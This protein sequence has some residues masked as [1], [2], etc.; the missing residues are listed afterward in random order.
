MPIARQVKVGAF[1][2]A[3][4]VVAGLVVF[5]IGDERRL[6]ESKVFYHAYFRDVQGLNRGSPVRMGGIDIGRVEEVSYMEDAKDA[7]LRVTMEIVDEEA[8][9]IRKD[10][11]ATVASKG[12]LGDKM[13]VITVGTPKEPQIPHGGIIP[14]EEAQDI[15]AMLDR[16]NTIGEKAENIAKNLEKTT[17]TFAEDQFREDV[18]ST[19]SSLNSILKSIDKGDGAASRFLHDPAEGER[20]S[21]TLANLERSTAQL[22]KTLTG[23]NA[24]INRVNTGPGFAH[25]VIYGEGPTETVK[26]FGRAAGELATT[27]EGIRR[28]N[29]LAKSVLYGD[30]GSQQ[31][32]GDLNAMA[33]DLRGIVADMRR[34]KG[35]IGALLVDPSVYEDL[36]M[37][38]GN[39]ERNKALR[40][41]VRYSIQRDE[42]VAP[43][44][45]RDP[46][47]TRGGKRSST[48]GRLAAE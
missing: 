27:L 42:K 32:M 39:V 11:V 25:D 16:V 13:I 40:A 1:V 30:D 41:L 23:V 19:L 9:R 47:P 15:S 37:M 7:R 34:G 26:Q 4:L 8:R 48:G 29:G 3:G 24:A 6:F 21:R 10:S 17:Q 43:V 33:H 18:R 31:I 5:L 35:T 12:L 45:I 46:A 22:D 2:F 14:S 20:L 28:G 36:K 44:E 38:L